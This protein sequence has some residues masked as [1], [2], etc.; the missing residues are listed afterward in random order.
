MLAEAAVAVLV[1]AEADEKAEAG[2]AELISAVAV[3]E[4]VAAVEPVRRKPRKYGG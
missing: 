1:V 3:E 4:V 2:V